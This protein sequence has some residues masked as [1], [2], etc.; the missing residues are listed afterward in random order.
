[1]L[2]LI[3][4]MV[5]EFIWISEVIRRHPKDL[6]ELRESDEVVTKWVIVGIWMV[7]LLLMIHLGSLVWSIIKPILEFF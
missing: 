2:F 7:T 3:V 6:A 1:M 5:M 4:I